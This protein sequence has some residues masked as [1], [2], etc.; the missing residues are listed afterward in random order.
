MLIRLRPLTALPN[1]LSL[2]SLGSLNGSKNE[3]RKNE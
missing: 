2:K 1:E 3:R